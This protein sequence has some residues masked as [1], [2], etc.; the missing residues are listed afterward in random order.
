MICGSQSFKPA[1]NSVLG[2]KPSR[3]PAS[4]GNW[5]GGELGRVYLWFCQNLADQVPN[6]P[7]VDKGHSRDTQDE[8]AAELASMGGV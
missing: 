4:G 6:S 1:D 3:L 2:T 8:V 5:G 7:V